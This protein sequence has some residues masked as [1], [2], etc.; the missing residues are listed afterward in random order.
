MIRLG[1]LGGYPF[2]GPSVLAGW[3]PPPRPGVFA[4]AYKPDSAG[5]RFAIIY[6]AH[7]DDLSRAGLPFD[8]PQAACWIGRAGNRYHL[9]VCTYEAPGG[10]AAHREQIVRE[11]VAVYRPGC[12]AEQYDQAWQDHW[13]GEYSAPTTGPLTT[14][15]DPG[16]R[17]P[18]T[19]ANA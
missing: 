10:S 16:R 6:V 13:I 18:G 3:A 4:I 1:S 19:S 17:D 8:H 2:E 7:T 11:L 14:H 5:E 9:Y 12:N 15:R